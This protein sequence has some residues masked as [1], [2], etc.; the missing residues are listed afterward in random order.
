MVLT[1]FRGGRNGIRISP[2]SQTDR[3]VCWAMKPLPSLPEGRNRTGP[4]LAIVGRSTLRLLVTECQK[5]GGCA[6]PLSRGVEGCVLLIHEHT[7]TTTQSNAPPL[8]RGI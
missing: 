6:I 8:K 3:L 5:T 4:L 1:N 2:K 7:P